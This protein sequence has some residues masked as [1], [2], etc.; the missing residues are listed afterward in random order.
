M[1]LQRNQ[2]F[3]DFGLEDLFDFA[4]AG[5]FAR[6]FGLFGDKFN[7]AFWTNRVLEPSLDTVLLKKIYEVQSL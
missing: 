2:G 1:R 6:Q 4:P 3:Q 5:I 7:V